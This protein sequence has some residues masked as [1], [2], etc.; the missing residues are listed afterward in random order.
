MG[1]VTFS[2]FTKPWKNQSIDELATLVSS[3]GF[4]GIEFPLRSGY[5]VEPK[6]AVKG[7]PALVRRLGDRGVAVTS[8][9]SSL[10]EPVFEACALSSVPVI[11]VMA[12]FGLERG[13]YG[14]EEAE[15]A[16]LRAALPLCERYGVKVGVQ[17]HYGTGVS[18]SMEL[19]R[20]VEEFDPRH[21]G[22][23]WDAAHSAL[24][25]EEP[26][27]GLLILRSHLCMV[28]FKNAF[29]RRVNGPEAAEARWERYFTLGSQGLGSWGA[30]AA[31]M[32][33]IGYEG[34]ACLT[35][36][37]TDEARVNEL[38]AQDIAYARSLFAQGGKKEA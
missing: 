8:V 16:A 4:N 19:M 1:N 3:L 23:V 32:D 18:G 12:N 25:G 21:V 20:F 24:A 38:I 31:A 14:G 34:V 15:K 2:V 28:N 30:A 17:H 35:A 9:A 27:Q 36:E 7:L 29:Y 6:D 5:Q 13:Y 11:R 26:L 10:D 22:A 33:A 37:Y